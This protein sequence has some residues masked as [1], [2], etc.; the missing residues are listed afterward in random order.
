MLK[1]QCGDVANRR[2]EALSSRLADLSQNNIAIIT[3]GIEPPKNSPRAS[4][5]STRSRSFLFLVYTQSYASHPMGRAGKSVHKDVRQD[6]PLELQKQ[7]NM[8][9]T[10]LFSSLA[11][12][13]LTRA[14]SF[15]FFLLAGMLI[16]TCF[17][18]RRYLLF[19]VPK[20]SIQE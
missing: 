6:V 20:G 5:T 16:Q 17:L 18:S 1:S 10:N 12:P 4:Y 2:P 13:I 7:A 3:T 15:V 8:A 19:V 9:S 11:Q 14:S